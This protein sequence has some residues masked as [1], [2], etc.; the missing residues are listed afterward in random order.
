MKCCPAM[1]AFGLS[2]VVG[3]TAQPSLESFGEPFEGKNVEVAWKVT[4][5]LPQTIEVF[6]AIP[7][8]PS[9][10]VLSNLVNVCKF[11]DP[12]GV[13]AVIQAA[14]RGKDVAYHEPFPGKAVM[15]KS[16]RI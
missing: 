14:V 8:K 2:S 6:K 4:K 3:L 12:A 9:L 11:K 5:P 16:L 10:E 13:W 1:L 15:G 7:A